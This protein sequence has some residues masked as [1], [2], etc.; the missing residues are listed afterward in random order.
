[1]TIENIAA[2]DKEVLTPAE[3]APLLRTTDQ[4]IRVCARQRP[5]L[6]GFPTIIMGSRVRIPRKPF[7]EFMGYKQ[8]REVMT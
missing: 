1:M 6:L 5:D 3:I 8:E 2:S 7:L 4:S